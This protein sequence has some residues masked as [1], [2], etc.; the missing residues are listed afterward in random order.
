[1]NANYALE[2]EAIVK[3]F[4]ALIAVNHVNLQIAPGTVH[5][6]C[7]ENGAGK[8]TL[9]R[10]LAGEYPDY[11]GTIR[12]R[13]QEVRINS[14]LQAKRQGIE[15]IHQELGL[16][17]PL[18]VAEN[19]LAG[20]LP[21]HGKSFFLNKR[22]AEA[23]TR[24]Y[25]D[26]VGLE[27]IKPS[28]LVSTLS[29]HEAQLVEIA[30]ALSNEP[31]ILIMDEPTSALTRDEVMLLFGIIE[32]LKSQ[33]LSI[34]YISHFLNE[35][36]EVSD[37]I[38]TMRDGCIISTE[39]TEALTQQRV[40]REM[41]GRDVQDFYAE[42][43]SRHGNTVL[44]VDRLTRYG[45]FRDVSFEVQEGE[46][47]GVCGLAGAGRS[48]LARA[49]V[50]IDRWD[51]GSVEFLGESFA[52]RGYVHAIRKGIA[53]LTEDRKLQGLALDQSIA[54]NITSAK[55][56]SQSRS[57]IVRKGGDGDIEGLMSRLKVIPHDPEKIVGRLSGG[58]QQKVL[59]AKW[60]N[61]DPKLLI[62]DEPTR[63]VDVGAKEMIHR[64]V[65][66]Y[67]NQGNACILISSD[68][69]ELIGL[70]D[71]VLILNH[72]RVHAIMDKSDCTEESL[73]IAA[74]G[75]VSVDK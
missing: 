33:G 42:H 67:V 56:A 39:R 69:M 21:R 54:A 63:G 10:I 52:N 27:R 28:T 55:G 64:T 25:L 29:Q 73:L 11:E 36:F 22:E 1:M 3:R 70:S 14:P 18:S 41:V 75:G 34:L 71:R 12:I 48:E 9:M 68:L 35:V 4:P 43:E 60:L 32:R 40:V 57:L 31:S 51:D 66:D 26:M 23:Q 37:F 38:T 65:K 61:I 46:I 59:L 8:S 5:A 13:G 74:N 7:G 20:R 17:R 24:K 44:K 53:Y 6:I 47:L 2:M 15:I 62:L 19:V 30:K 72:G 45:F 16:A 49:L 58:N 50:G